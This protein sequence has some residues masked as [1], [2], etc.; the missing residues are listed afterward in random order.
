MEVLHIT[1]TH[2][3]LTEISHIATLAARESEKMSFYCGRPC[4]QDKVKLIW[5]KEN[6]Y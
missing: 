2:I 1:F 5:K 3:P 6:D 4:N